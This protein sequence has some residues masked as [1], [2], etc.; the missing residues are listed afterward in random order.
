MNLKGLKHEIKLLGY[1][2]KTHLG[3][4]YETFRFLSVYKDG[5]FVCG[6][7]ANVY[8]AEHIEKHKEV[9]DLLNLYRG[10]VFDD[11]YEKPLKVLF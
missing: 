2:T 11:S 1:Q 7:S 4:V 10:K 3:G 5:E 8:P 6:S 9:F